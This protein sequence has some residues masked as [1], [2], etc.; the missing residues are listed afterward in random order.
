MK[1]VNLTIKEKDI[2]KYVGN[3]FLLFLCDDATILYAINKID[4]LIRRKVGKFPVKE[5]MSLLHMTYNPKERRFYEQVIMH[6]KTPTYTFINV[7]NDVFMKLPDE[8]N[9][10]MIL[11]PMCGHPEIVLNYKQFLETILKDQS[12]KLIKNNLTY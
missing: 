11:Y 5:F 1:K 8:T 6:A 7:R 10:L 4:W 12:L 3:E 9:I 2:N